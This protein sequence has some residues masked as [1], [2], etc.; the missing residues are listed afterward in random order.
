[1]WGGGLMFGRQ[2]L[3]VFGNGNSYRRVQVPMQLVCEASVS[4]STCCVTV[5]KSRMFPKD[6]TR[7]VAVMNTNAFGEPN[8]CVRTEYNSSN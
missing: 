1:M 4:F 8:S 5:K 7:L 2:L 3:C 6:I